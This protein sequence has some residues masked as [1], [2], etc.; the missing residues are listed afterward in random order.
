LIQRLAYDR[1]VIMFDYPLVGA[2]RNVTGRPADLDYSVEGLAASV[3]QFVRSLKLAKKPD[4]LGWSLG[5]MVAYAM[6]A[7][8]GAE[9]E[10]ILAYSSSS[11]GQYSFAPPQGT[12]EN[13]LRVRS[14]DNPEFVKYFFP[15]GAKDAG[16]CPLY[17]S[18]N[19][20]YRSRYTRVD[21]LTLKGEPVSGWEC[22]DGWVGPGSRWK[23]SPC[24]LSSVVL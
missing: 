17:A 24:G 13:F 15:K 22:V 3:M 16:V 1:E 11:G 23:A 18:W 7:N 20:F 9:L 5:G 4:I 10:N 14:S 8:Y 6:A 21:R 2:S 12:W 19:S